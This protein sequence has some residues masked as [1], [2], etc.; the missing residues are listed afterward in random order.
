MN[1]SIMSTV[2]I[3]DET[4]RYAREEQ[5]AIEVGNYTYLVNPLFRTCD[6]ENAADRMKSYILKRSIRTFA[7][8]AN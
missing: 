2:P 5:R 4:E 1:T 3:V 6:A 7:S 8:D